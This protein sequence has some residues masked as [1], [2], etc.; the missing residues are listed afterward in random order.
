MENRNPLD[1]KIQELEDEIEALNRVVRGDPNS[2]VEG[3]VQK[4]SDLRVEVKAIK[5]ARSNEKS[6]RDADD[7]RRQGQ[8]DVLRWSRNVAFF[9]T[10]GS[11][12][13][14]AVALYLAFGGAAP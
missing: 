13:G 10:G 11:L 5:E 2:Y 8:M 7:A 1:R 12:I 4:V 9:L 3:L 14:T 6:S